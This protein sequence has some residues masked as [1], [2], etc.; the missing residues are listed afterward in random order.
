[1]KSINFHLRL[2]KD[3]DPYPLRDQKY[4]PYKKY[5]YIIEIVINKYKKN[6]ECTITWRGRSWSRGLCINGRKYNSYKKCKKSHKK[7]H[8][9]HL[10][11]YKHPNQTLFFLRL[12]NSSRMPPSMLES[13]C[14]YIHLYR[15]L[16]NHNR[17]L[18]TRVRIR[19]DTGIVELGGARNLCTYT[20]FPH[21][22]NDCLEYFSI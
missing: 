13:V 12:N 1:M 20:Y 19:T 21:V 18:W 15:V 2:V 7:C 9:Q 5:T 3:P 11:F 10:H 4:I 16:G 17:W 14:I 8:S 6:W 22:S